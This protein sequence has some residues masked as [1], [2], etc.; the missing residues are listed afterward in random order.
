VIHVRAEES[1][2]GFKEKESTS[3]L[4]TNGCHSTLTL[5]FV[6]E[7][8][9]NSLPDSDSDSD[10]GTPFDVLGGLTDEEEALRKA[11]GRRPFTKLLWLVSQLCHY[12]NRPAKKRY[13]C[14]GTN[15]RKTWATSRNRA[16]ILK[17]VCHCQ[18]LEQ[19][20]DEHIPERRKVDESDAEGKGT[21]QVVV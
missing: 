1:G 10:G 16:R 12:R 2:K 20:D 4:T 6:Q 18:H 8:P 19:Q 5:Y 14:L 7:S 13:R 11:T 3:H 17:H 15:R 21:L 9:V